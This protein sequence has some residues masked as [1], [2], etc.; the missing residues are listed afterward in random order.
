MVVKAS[1]FD[2]ADLSAE[3]RWLMDVLKALGFDAEA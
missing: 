2:E 3:G 1:G